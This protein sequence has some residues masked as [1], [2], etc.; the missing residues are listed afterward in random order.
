[1]KHRPRYPLQPLRISGGW[2]ITLNTFHQLPFTPETLEWFDASVLIGGVH[3]QGQRCFDCAF[4]PEDDPGGEFV[5]SLMTYPQDRSNTVPGQ[6]ELLEE[7]KTRDTA[8]LIAR[9]EAFMLD[10]TQQADPDSGHGA[11]APLQAIRLPAGWEI[12]HHQLPQAALGADTL[13]AF[14]H[15]LLLAGAGREHGFTLGFESAPQ[16]LGEF[17]LRVERFKR[18]RQRQAYNRT[19][20]GEL[21]TPDPHRA[22]DAIEQFAQ[23]LEWQLAGP[24]ACLL[25][26]HSE[27]GP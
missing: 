24:D 27:P 2:Q 21:R 20:A 25:P 18:N 22:L 3:R 7:F 13:P 8:Q 11:I 6:E 14:N 5:L 17:V 1:M 16:G 26:T 4:L 12:S 19:P 15:P 23:G 10:T 9:L